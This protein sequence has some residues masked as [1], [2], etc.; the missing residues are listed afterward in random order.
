MQRLFTVRQFAETV[1]AFSEASIR[2]MVFKAS[3]NGLAESGAILRMG[4]RVLIDSDKFSSWIES[5]Q[6]SGFSGNHSVSGGAR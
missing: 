6:S 4:R 5:K 3:T 1:P 2:W